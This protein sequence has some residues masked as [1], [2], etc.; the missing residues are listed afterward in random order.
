ME[1]ELYARL[2]RDEEAR[3]AVLS[4]QQRR[5]QTE[6]DYVK[7]VSSQHTHREDLEQFAGGAANRLAAATRERDE[8]VK[9]MQEKY[10]GEVGAC[11]SRGSGGCS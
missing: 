9:A 8:F 5:A 2:T 11:R 3:Y 1:R 6:H 4:R 7:R 10:A